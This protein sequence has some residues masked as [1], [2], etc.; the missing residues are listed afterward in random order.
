MGVSGI[1][2][3]SLGLV[4]ATTKPRK[5]CGS[6]QQKPI[7]SL[8]VLGTRSLKSRCHQGPAPSRLWVEAFLASPG[9]GKEVEGD[10]CLRRHRA[11]F[12]CVLY[13]ISSHKDTHHIGSRPTFSSA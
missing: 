6:K 8:T 9:G 3:Q 12:Q 4:S 1:R 5:P 7:P 11:S 2:P 13:L 10:F